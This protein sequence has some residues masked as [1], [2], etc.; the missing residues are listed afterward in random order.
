VTG[1]VVLAAYALLACFGTR[2]SNRIAY[3][4]DQK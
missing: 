3:K 1:W 2:I 4:G